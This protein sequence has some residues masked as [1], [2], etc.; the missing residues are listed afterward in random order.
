MK[1]RV[2]KKLVWLSLALAL[3]LAGASTASAQPGEFVKGVLQPLADGFPKR[4]IAL[5]VVDDPGSRDGIYARQMQAALKGISPVDIL[6]SDEPSSSWG[7]WVK[8]KEMP[9]RNGGSDGYYPIVVNVYASATDPLVE[10]ITEKLDLDLSDMNM[11]IV[12][13]KQPYTVVQKKNAP[14]GRKFADMIAWAKAN[15]GKLR[16]PT[17]GVGTAQ[18]ISGSAIMKHYG[19]KDLKI[20][21]PSTANALAAVGAGEG[22]VMAISV[23]ASLPHV[24]AGKMD[25][26]MIFGSTVPP[27]WDKDPNVTTTDAAGLSFLSPIGVQL[28]FCVTKDIPK[29]HIDW[30]AKLF[31]AAAATDTYKQREKTM[32]GW[33]S[34]LLGP[35]DANALKESLAKLA[36]PIIR[37]IGLHVDQKK[38]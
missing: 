3:T 18:D 33:Q 29:D 23:G 22:D 21:Q 13:E 8:L 15:P 10:P 20:P 16:R 31:K 5:V 38:K 32:P 25:Y 6:V 34:N 36:D 26:S 28:G 7:L 9:S 14:W 37:D 24:Q 11:V 30:L 2:S 35:A 4:A 27:P 17:D 1:T 19:V 12:T